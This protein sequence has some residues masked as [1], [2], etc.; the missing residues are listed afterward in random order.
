[1][2]YLGLFLLIPVIWFLVGFVAR[3]LDKDKVA[4][5]FSLMD[6][7]SLTLATGAVFMPVVAIAIA[8]LLVILWFMSALCNVFC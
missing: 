6:E 5:P 1:M 8:A 7:V 3:V 2:K 4:K